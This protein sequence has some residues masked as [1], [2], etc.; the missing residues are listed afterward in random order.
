MKK[1]TQIEGIGLSYSKKLA[2]AG[3][4][5]QSQLLSTCSKRSRREQLARETG[6]SVKLILKWTNQAD[7]ARIKGVG[8][9]YGELLERTGVDSVPELAQRNAE[10]LCEMIAKTN[11]RL[12]LVRHEPG[13]N[14]VSDWIDQA[15]HLPKVVFH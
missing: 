11:H 5:D 3:I 7:L 8:E 4:G 2:Q 10:S 6:I 13:L 1:L 12:H 9:E 15:K 14:K